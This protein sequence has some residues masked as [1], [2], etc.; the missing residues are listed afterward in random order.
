M[1]SKEFQN[2]IKAFIE[3][4]EISVEEEIHLFHEADRNLGAACFNLAEDAAKKDY[5]E[6]GQSAKI[7]GTAYLSILRNLY[8]FFPEI[9]T[10]EE[11]ARKLDVYNHFD[12]SNEG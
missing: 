1:V 3:G 5:R 9:R 6:K 2:R 7:R 8:E 10:P 4:L 11:S 12:D